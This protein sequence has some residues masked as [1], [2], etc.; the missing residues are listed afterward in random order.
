[1]ES[2]EHCLYSILYE[3]NSKTNCIYKLYYLNIATPK[4]LHLKLNTNN[5]LTWQLDFL[6]FPPG[7]IILFCTFSIFSSMKKIFPARLCVILFISSRL[8]QALSA[9]YTVWLDR[10][11]R[12]QNIIFLPILCQYCKHHANQ[13]NNYT[14]TSWKRCIK[15]SQTVKYGSISDISSK[16]IKM[17]VF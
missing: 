1:M 4:G 2:V 10:R 12:P 16:I 17:A 14:Y 15:S 6:R 9:F 8:M 3:Q 7:N 5:Q 13:V 11:Y